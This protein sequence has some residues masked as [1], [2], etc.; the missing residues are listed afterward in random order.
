[1]RGIAGKNAD[2]ELQELARRIAEA[3]IDLKRVRSA[4]HDLLSSAI[5]DP[6]YDSPRTIR[7]KLKMA[8]ILAKYVRSPTQHADIFTSF[9]ASVMELI[10]SKP[11]G[12]RETRNHFFRHDS[13]ACSHGPL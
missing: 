13:A 10:Q 8:Q 11:E 1:M 5:D 6:D 9:N 7:A 12:S 3:Q 4:R 2:L